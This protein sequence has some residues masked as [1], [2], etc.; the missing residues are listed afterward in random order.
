MTFQQSAVTQ[1]AQSDF[2]VTIKSDQENLTFDH[3]VVACGAWSK[4]LLKGLNYH[5]PINEQDTTLLSRP[6]ASAERRFII[7]PMEKTLRLAGKVEYSGLNAPANYKRAE[8][9]KDNAPLF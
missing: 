6:V 8:M 1:V 2:G 4:E 9:L 5:L 7:T 3:C